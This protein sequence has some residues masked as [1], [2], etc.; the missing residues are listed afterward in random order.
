MSA[1]QFYSKRVGY[2][3]HRAESVRRLAN[4]ELLVI[5]LAVS[6]SEVVD[7]RIPPNVI[8]GFILGYTESLL[9]NNHAHFALIVESLGKLMVRENVIS[10]GNNGGKALCEDD[11]MCWLILFVRAVKARLIELFG[12]L[13][14]IFSDA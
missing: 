3:Y 2:I 11:R 9:P 5:S 14:I 13:G 1:W 8:H 4:V 7:N 6:R 12:M 10:V